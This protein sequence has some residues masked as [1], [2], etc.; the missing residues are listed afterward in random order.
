MSESSSS[1][2][3]GGG[4]A[5]KTCGALNGF[6]PPPDIIVTVTGPDGSGI[7]SWCGEDWN[8]DEPGS[9]SGVQKRVCPISYDQ[10]GGP[11]V[12]TMSLYTTFV[13]DHYWRYGT[14]LSLYRHAEIRGAPPFPFKN[15][16]HTNK[17]SINGVYDYLYEAV[18][19][20]NPTP[21]V[22]STFASTG[23]GF[24][25]NYFGVGSGNS[26]IGPAMIGNITDAGIT[27]TWAKGNGWPV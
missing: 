27:Y 10:V 20:Q 24:M 1:E 18:Q 11:E 14:D 5:P 4:P 25:T 19:W 12:S 3:G 9:E 21:S 6:D 7:I 2:G 13:G 23:L 8:L 22:T 17:V 16:K 26:L 15:K